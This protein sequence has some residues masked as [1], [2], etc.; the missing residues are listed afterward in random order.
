M[1]GVAAALG[2]NEK[3]EKPKPMCRVTVDGED[4]VDTAYENIILENVKRTINKMAKEI[5]IYRL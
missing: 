2:L 5:R 3:V 1:K 4:L